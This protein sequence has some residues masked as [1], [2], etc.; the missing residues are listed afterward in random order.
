MPPSQARSVG[1]P[2]ELQQVRTHCERIRA[3][4]R[5]LYEWIPVRPLSGA[6]V[7]RWTGLKGPLC[8]RV[9]AAVQHRGD[10]AELARILPGVEG[11]TLFVE[12]L[13]RKGCP[14]ERTEPARQAISVFAE[15]MHAGGG[16]QRKLVSAIRR[17]L[18]GGESAEPV[19]GDL[20]GTRQRLFEA[21]RDLTGVACDAMVAVSIL[22][23]PDDRRGELDTVGALGRLGYRARPGAPPLI[24]KYFS[25]VGDEQ[26]APVEMPGT[27]LQ[28]HFGTP[29]LDITQ[30]RLDDERVLMTCEAPG[31]SGAPIELWN[32]PVHDPGA[33]R[34][35]GGDG[36]AYSSLATIGSPSRTL[37]HDLWLETSLARASVLRAGVYRS[38]PDVFASMDYEQWYDRL[39]GDPQILL[40]GSDLGSGVLHANPQ[41]VQVLEHCFEVAG[42]D[43]A[44]F[45]GYRCVVEHPI[46]M[47]AYRLTLEFDPE[48]RPSSA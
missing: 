11:L 20:S 29:D 44:D 1:A 22:Y 47:A 33:V 12:A 2:I 4:F 48:F 36:H 25:H 30:T 42:R 13:E 9:L 45:V 37:V 46:W 7:A 28:Q 17:G 26:H 8:R 3:E 14:P 41:H 40:P 31:D 19:T 21:A 10:P 43:P 38:S 35:D 32:G 34:F 24:S 39:P 27:G 23:T 15:L 16:S 18:E 5:G 6:A